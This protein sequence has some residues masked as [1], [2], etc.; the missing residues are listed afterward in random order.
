MAYRHL[1]APG[2]IGAMPLR[3]RIF[4]TPMGSNLADEDGITGDRLRAYY[5]A[6]A[7]GGAAL[8]TMGSVSIGYPDGSGNWRNEAT[9]TSG[10]CPASGR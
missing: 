7:K 4:M 10:M 3:N 5:E 6:R 8:I 2:R 9:P 1:L